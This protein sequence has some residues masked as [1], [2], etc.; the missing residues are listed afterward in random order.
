MGTTLYNK[1]HLGRHSLL[2]SRRARMM[3]GTGLCA[4]LALAWLLLGAER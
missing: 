3:L 4:G 1:I 2:A